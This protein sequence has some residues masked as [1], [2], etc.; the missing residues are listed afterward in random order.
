MSQNRHLVDLGAR[1]EERVDE[2]L[3]ELRDPDEVDGG[4]IVPG[5][6]AMQNLPE[7]AKKFD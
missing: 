6:Q 1:L 3:Q 5:K 7:T 4:R 2:E